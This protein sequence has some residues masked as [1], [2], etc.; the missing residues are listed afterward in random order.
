VSSWRTAFNDSTSKTLSTTVCAND[1]IVGPDKWKD[2]LPFAVH[3][4]ATNPEDAF[5]TDYSHEQIENGRALVVCSIKETKTNDDILLLDKSR[6][7]L[8]P[9]VK[10]LEKSLSR[11]ASVW[12]K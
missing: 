1:A 2:A 8:F 7:P 10:E 3:P 9:G 5:S 12:Y 6:K 11:T 4:N